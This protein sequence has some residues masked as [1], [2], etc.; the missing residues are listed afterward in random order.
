MLNKMLEPLTAIGC[1]LG[2]CS[3]G[4][5]DGGLT[6]GA[7]IGGA[8]LV[9]RFREACAKHGFDSSQLIEKMRLAVMRDWDRADQPEEEREAIARASNAI[10]VHIADCL[11]SREELA[12][13]ALKGERVYP[14]AAAA[15]VVDRLAERDAECAALFAVE[16][17]ARRFA[18]AVV[19]RALRLAKD[20]PDYAP[21]LT[22]DLV[23]EIAGGVGRIERA[24]ERDAAINL[25]TNAMVQ[26]L[27]DKM[28]AEEQARSVTDEAL[29]AL[30]RKIAAQVDDPAEALAALGSAID[31]F[32]RV[33]ESAARG[34][35]LGELVDQTLRNIAAANERGALDEGA[36]LGARAFAEW[37]ERQEA[38]RQAGLRLIEANIE[39]QRL[40]FDAAAMAHWIGERLK[41]LGGGTI[42]FGAL[43][44]VWAEWYQRGLIRGLRLDLDVSIALARLSIEFASSK[45]DWAVAQN[46]LAVSLNNQGERTGGEAGLALLAEAV[47]A[48]RAALTVRTESAMPAQWAMTQNNLGTALQAQGERT[49][50]EAGL[51]LLADA[52]AAYRAALTVYTESAMPANW[53]MTQNNL[54]IALRSQGERTGGQA[55]LALLAE[56]VT[57]YRAA[58]TVYTESAM[59]ANWAAT[60]NNLG[61]ALGHLGE[62]I[63]GASGLALLNEAAAAFRQAL[64]ILTAEHFSHQHEGADRSLRHALTLI[65]K[66][67]S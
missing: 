6:A 33:R 38:Q 48:Y 18:L 8:A 4:A 65:A 61:I 42:D 12:A 29:I 57:A 46:D 22:L 1:A 28:R 19:E 15:L 43:R 21:L 67:T 58:L 2:A 25:D 31:E 37:E 20:D 64:T 35:N 54:G 39:Q 50:G 36:R 16:T 41:L 26:A 11:P 40:R 7:V 30:A 45:R 9:A 5:L 51:A 3:I 55:G 62:R 13:T 60:Q 49:G 52:V 63:S 27:F 32:L 23:I 34:T 66:R 17:T 44:F 47:A 56:A 14:A 24:V 53:A 10:G 59:P